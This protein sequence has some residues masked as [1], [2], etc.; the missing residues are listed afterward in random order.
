[1]RKEG[2]TY[3]CELDDICN[4]A[5]YIERHLY[6]RVWDRVGVTPTE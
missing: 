1:M 3:I 5:V 6:S 2:C 4:L